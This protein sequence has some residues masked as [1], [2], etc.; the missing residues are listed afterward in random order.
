MVETLKECVRQGSF[1]RG[2][3]ALYSTWFHSRL[4]EWSWLP[5]VMYLRRPVLFIQPPESILYHGRCAMLWWVYTSFHFSSNFSSKG[6]STPVVY[7]LSP[8]EMM[9]SHLFREQNSPMASATSSWWWCPEPQSPI[10]TK[11]ISS[12]RVS[13]TWT[14]LSLK[15]MRIWS[16]QW[17]S[18]LI[19]CALA[20]VTPVQ[21]GRTDKERWNGQK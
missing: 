9:K 17:S 18:N 20:N 19:V 15:A 13:S 21:R 16:M 2:S 1:H 3:N 6:E 10:A 7:M 4:N 11:W 8:V 14:C 5:T 12:W